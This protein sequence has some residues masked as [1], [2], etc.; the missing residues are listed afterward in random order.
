M[1]CVVQSMVS[2]YQTYAP[3]YSYNVSGVAMPY[4]E[5]LQS[6][7]STALA[8]LREEATTL[9]ADG[10][11]DIRLSTNSLGGGEEFLAMGTAV[12]ARSTTRPTSLFTTELSGSD[13]AKLM[14]A[15]WVPVQVEWA[16]AAN[17]VFTGYATQAQTSFYAGNTEV[18]SYTALINRVRADARRRFHD[19]VRSVGA[20]G[21]IVSRM[22]LSTWEPGEQVVAALASVYGTAVAK[23][24]R[25]GPAPA[26]TLTVMPLRRQ[27]E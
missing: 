14:L 4:L 5:A 23:F 7:Y 21:G 6:G 20:D 15:G 13:V 10:V 12:R 16:G 22:A 27:G 11:V 19:M 1:G 24:H 17:A 8:R 2:R 3:V 25:G 26:R 9:G 18:D